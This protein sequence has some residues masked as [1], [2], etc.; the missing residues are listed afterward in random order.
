MPTNSTWPGA[1]RP[2]PCRRSP[3]PDSSS[4]GSLAPARRVSDTRT[5]NSA[6]EQQQSILDFVLDDTVALERQLGLRDQQK[7]D[8][9]LTSVREIEH[10]IQRS[11]KFKDVP[12]PAVDTP[13]GIPASFR[14]TFS[15]CST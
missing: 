13:A 2:C 15:S 10:R 3:I 14:T 6:S 9:Y 5:S 12:D 4:S 1:A 11:E 8:E 7:L